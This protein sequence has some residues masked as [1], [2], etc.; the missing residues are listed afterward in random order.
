MRICKAFEPFRDCFDAGPAL[1]GPAL[2]Q[3]WPLARFFGKFAAANF[4]PELCRPTWHDLLSGKVE[5][6]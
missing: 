1:E 6:A 5:F 2:G 4:H 3:K